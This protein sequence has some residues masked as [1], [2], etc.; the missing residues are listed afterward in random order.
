MNIIGKR[1]F[2]GTIRDSS[3]SNWPGAFYSLGRLFIGLLAYIA[4]L[5]AIVLVIVGIFGQ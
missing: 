1:D 5:A 3:P 2:L 4:T